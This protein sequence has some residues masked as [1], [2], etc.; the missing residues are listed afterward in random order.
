MRMLR[1]DDAARSPDLAG[2]RVRQASVIVGLLDGTRLRVVH[3]TFSVL[4]IGADGFED[5]ERPSTRQL[6]GV[7]A[8]FESDG[9]ARGQGGPIIGAARR[10]VARGGA[11]EPDGRVRQ[12]IEAAASGQ[13][14]C[15]RVRA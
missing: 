1:R 4:D 9:P 5:V 8:P 2:Q 3:G 11:A 7:D 6:A 15:P 12:R 10:F 14:P 13:L